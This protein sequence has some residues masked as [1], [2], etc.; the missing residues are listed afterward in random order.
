LVADHTITA[1]RRTPVSAV[2]CKSIQ[3]SQLSSCACMLLLLLLVPAAAR[4]TQAAYRSI[5]WWHQQSC[6]A[7]LSDPEAASAHGPPTQGCHSPALDGLHPR[8][9]C[10]L[11]ACRHALTCGLSVS[12]A[13]VR[14]CRAAWRIRRA[15]NDTETASLRLS[16]HAQA[17]S[18][19]WLPEAQPGPCAQRGGSAARSAMI[20]H[21][22][23]WLRRAHAS[24]KRVSPEPA[25][26]RHDRAVVRSVKVRHVAAAVRH[27]FGNHSYSA[28][29]TAMYCT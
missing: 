19:G 27:G 23:Q 5:P 12:V 6:S 14:V 26:P 25:A 24:A 21:G 9:G 16:H 15:S 20:V 11:H 7:Y 13:F 8:M 28:P 10:G 1:E 4:Q 18:S 29:H 17:A 3:G 2:G 22:P